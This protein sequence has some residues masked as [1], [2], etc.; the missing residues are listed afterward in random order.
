MA[1]IKN[2]CIE[3]EL[4]DGQKVQLT[5]AFYRLYQ[6]KAK[7]KDLYSHYNKIMTKGPEEELDMIVILYTAY[8]CANIEH[9]E[10][11]M[12]ELEFM[13]LV[14]S[15]RKVIREIEEELIASKKK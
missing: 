10:D 8:L 13:K 6:L 14:P 4:E 11:C 7:N 15:N 12:S 3:M 1:N 9:V 5:L 2:T